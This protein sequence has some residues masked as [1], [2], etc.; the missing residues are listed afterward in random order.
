VYRP[1][2][3]TVWFILACV[4]VLGGVFYLFYRLQIRNIRHQQRLRTQI[5]ADLYEDVGAMLSRM[6]M[7]AE[8]ANYAKPD[9]TKPILE[10]ILNTSRV[11]LDTMRDLIWSID[12]RYDTCS[13]MLLRMEEQLEEVLT[14]AGIGYSFDTKNAKPEQ[15]ISP[16]LRREVF[17]IFKEAL[18]NAVKIGQAASLTIYF[19]YTGTHLQMIM[20][21]CYP[22]QSLLTEQLQAD[23]KA[24]F[25][26]AIQR[27]ERLRASL[28]IEVTQQGYRLK[29]VKK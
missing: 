27:A 6:A 4:A 25:Q 20:E 17:F 26:R 8:M 14:P 2:Y 16:Q 23:S 3:L 29:L 13:D 19:S 18:D 7:Q 11:T 9:R 5:A 15:L 12:A 24:A 10:D 1:F 22:P 21:E 28:H